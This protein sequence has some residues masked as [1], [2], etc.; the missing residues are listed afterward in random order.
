MIINS[1][2][3]S[4]KHWKLS[5][6]LN[7]ICPFHIVDRQRV[8]IMDAEDALCH[9]AGYPALYHWSW[10]VLWLHLQGIHTVSQDV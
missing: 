9:F 5:H 6:F 2:Q 1:S 4:V 10:S 3:I 7:V 8:Q